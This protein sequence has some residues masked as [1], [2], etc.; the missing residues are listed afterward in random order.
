MHDLALQALTPERLVELV[1]VLDLSEARKIATMAETYYVPVAPHNCGGPI[2][3]FA[4]MHLAMNVT[5]LFILESV[6]AHY[7]GDYRGL[8]TDTGAAKDGVLRAPDGPG[9]STASA[10][11]PWPACSRRPRGAASSPPAAWPRAQ[12]CRRRCCRSSC[13]A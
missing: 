9:R 1:P 7:N 2:L 11:A 13:A 8:V 5:N 4:S 12:T 3:H 10:A 6:R